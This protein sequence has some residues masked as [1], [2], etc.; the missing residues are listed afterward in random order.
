MAPPPAP[1]DA[2]SALASS[3]ATKADAKKGTVPST[4]IDD[5]RRA[6]LKY[7]KLSKVG[8]VE[9][10]STEFTKCT[11]IQIKNS[12]EAVAERTG[13]GIDKTWKLKDGCVV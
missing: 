2:F 11:K 10:L 8:L 9:I 6:I 3:A 4:L 5:F 7:P 1:A 13:T 12:L